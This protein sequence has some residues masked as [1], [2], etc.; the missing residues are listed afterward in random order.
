MSSYGF[1]RVKINVYSAKNKNNWLVY[2]LWGLR[3]WNETSWTLS[4]MFYFDAF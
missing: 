2:D 3:H 1:F 4:P